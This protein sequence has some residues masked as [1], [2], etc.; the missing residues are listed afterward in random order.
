M[1]K[2]KTHDQFLLLDAGACAIAAGIVMGQFITGIWPALTLATGIGATS[3]YFATRS[4]FDKLFENLGLKAG[5]ATPRYKGKVATDYSTIYKFRLPPGLSSGDFQKKQLAIEEHLGSP[6][7][8][9]YTYKMLHIEVFKEKSLPTR[10]YEVYECKGDIAFPVGHNREGTLIYCNLADGEPHMLI[11]GET[12]SGKSTILRTIITNLILTKDAELYLIDLKSGAEFA[13]F[14]NS[15]KVKG[16]AKSRGEAERL[17]TKI[18]TEVDCRYDTFYNADCVDIKEYNKSHTP[19]P[20]QVIIVDEFAD[21]REEKSSITMLED[22]AAKAR[23]CGIHL[24]ISTQRPDAKVLNGRIKANVTTVLG[25]K[26]TNDVNSRIIIDEGGLE[27]LSGKGHAIFK[28]GFT[29]EIQC[30]YLSPEKAKELIKP[31]NGRKSQEPV[32][33]SK[34]TE[35][36]LEALI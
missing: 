27:K 9:Q 34:P 36:D 8:I 29:S 16:F 7:S 23:A 3:Y 14:R 10:D 26:T 1:D 21:L 5:T 6:V 24:I 19:L 12:G 2:S 11:A 30:P 33:Q 32:I 22:L 17:L 31:F 25:L 28:R 4:H 35:I 15:S 13:I 18:S 20:Y